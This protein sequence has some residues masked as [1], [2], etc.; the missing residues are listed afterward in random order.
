MPVFFALV[1]VK[2]R[3][4]EIIQAGCFCGMM[5]YRLHKSEI[6]DCKT[7]APGFIAAAGCCKSA[8]S[9]FISAT[10]QTYSKIIDN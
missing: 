3:L 7:A 2:R 9:C 5:L 6:S 10:I 1:N 8:A 4:S